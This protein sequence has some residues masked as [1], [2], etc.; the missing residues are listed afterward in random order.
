VPG[1]CCYDAASVARP[2]ALALTLT[3]AFALL[4]WGTSELAAQSTSK[5]SVIPELIEKQFE[6]KANQSKR[7]KR[8][9]LRLPPVRGAS[10]AAGLTTL[11]VLRAVELSGATALSTDELAESYRSLLGKP[12]SEAD[13]VHIVERISE[14]YRQRG[15]V[16]SRAVLAPQD[17]DNGR[18]RITVLEGRI[19]DIVLKGDGV[20]RFGVRRLLEPILAQRPLKLE[21]L[22]RHLLLVNDTPGARI[23]DAA[24]EELGEATGRF[25]LIVQLQTW[26]TW[27]GFDLDNRGTPAIGPLQAFIATA[28]NSPVLGGE[29]LAVNLSTS[30]G[31]SRELRFAGL[32][33]D[34]PLGSDGA[35]LGLSASHSDIWPGDERRTLHGRIRTESY[36]VSATIAALRS[37]TSSLWLS[38]IATIRDEEESNSLGNVYN[39]HIRALAARAAYQQHDHLRG[40]NYLSLTVRQGVDI[41]DA[42]ER[43]DALLS[44]ADGSGSFSKVHVTLTRQ[45]LLSDQWSVVVSGAAQTSST[46]LLASEEFYLGGAQFGRA[47][48]SADVSG[49]AGAAAFAEVRF[50]QPVENP[51]VKSYQL[52]GFM[53]TGT[54][55]DR[56]TGGRRISLS[57]FGGGLR[58]A[59][60]DS[61]FASFEIAM[62]MGEYSASSSNGGPALFL[63]LSKAF[64]SCSDRFILL[65][66]SN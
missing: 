37:Q 47:F 29:T 33:L 35:R 40:S 55:W 5:G 34:V 46:G 1:R 66:P 31:D 57:S 27:A 65:C 21:T 62:P 60:E 39:D 52:Y 18:L 20:D 28:F 8:P 9:D 54:V 61:F 12:V 45:Q 10:P 36:A 42:S 15:F 32:L 43:G 13:L 7:D 25:R 38:A 63:T 14:G 56:N 26:R 64:K 22:D 4:I 48:R 51:I 58:L 44:R 17:V 24:I 19:E 2:R 53:D 6:T 3:T 50:E 30:P 11:F 23:V 16:L 49:D 41:L 59:L